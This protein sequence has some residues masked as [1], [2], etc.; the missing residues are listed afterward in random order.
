[1]S[2]LRELI[3]DK[4][5]YEGFDAS[6]YEPDL[7]GWGSDHPFLISA[8][9]RV[10]PKRI[11]EVGTWKGRSAINMA[12]AVKRL[13]IDCEIV[14]VDTWLGSPEHWLKQEPGWYESLKI[15]NGFPSLYRTFL[16]NVVHEG[17]ADIIT[18]F[19]S[20]SDNASYIFKKKAIYFD[21]CYIDAAHEYEPV[22]KDLNN[23]WG[24][25]KEPG[26]LIGD[27]YTHDW[28]EVMGAAEEFAK[29]K[30]LKLIDAGGK[31]AIPK[32]NWYPSL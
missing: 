13:G 24:V 11:V 1:M 8:I 31:Y 4:S 23:Y 17:V 27:D 18:P 29:Q 16:T 25:L 10:R 2:S 12:K 15:E 19:P 28:P 3:Y 6:L 14:C 5:P 20:T 21:I 7:Q 9:E 32:G 30:N 22:L 26:L